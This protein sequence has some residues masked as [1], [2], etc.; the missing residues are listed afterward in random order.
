VQ[1]IR[2]AIADGRFQ[3]DS[4]VVA[5]RLLSSARELLLQRG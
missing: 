1:S 4:G 5:D 3:V 2:Q